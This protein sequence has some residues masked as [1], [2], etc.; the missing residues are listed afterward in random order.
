MATKKALKDLKCVM[1]LI[2]RHCLYVARVNVGKMGIRC[3]CDCE[4]QRERKRL[5]A[6]CLQSLWPAGNIC[7]IRVP[8]LVDNEAIKRAFTMPKLK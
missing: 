3:H 6:K 2:E 5:N 4:T 1:C 8:N 7:V